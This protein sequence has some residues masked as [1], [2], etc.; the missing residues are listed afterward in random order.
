M[1]ETISREELK[2]KMDRED[3]FVLIDTLAEMYYRHSHLPGAINVPA[4]EVG[5]RIPELLPD[6]EAEIVVYCMDPPC[7]GLGARRPQAR[8]HGLQERAGLRRRKAGLEGA[9][10]PRRGQA[11]R[12]KEVAP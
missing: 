1:V 2:E 4:D 3:D 12:E 11:L 7:G 9:R 10:P 8:G 5:E 6:R